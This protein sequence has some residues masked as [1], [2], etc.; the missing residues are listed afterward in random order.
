MSAKVDGNGPCVHSCYASWEQK[1]V[2]CGYRN[3]KKPQKVSMEFCNHEC[4]KRQEEII[5]DDPYD[6]RDHWC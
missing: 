1:M 6:W 3:M 5:D 4:S 2:L